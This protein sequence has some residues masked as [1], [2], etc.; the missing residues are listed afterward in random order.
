MAIFTNNVLGLMVLTLAC[1]LKLSTTL[2]VPE[3]GNYGIEPF[4]LVKFSVL[5]DIVLTFYHI[6]P[7]PRKIIQIFHEFCV[8]YC[9]LGGFFSM[10]ADA[11]IINLT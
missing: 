11:K 3:P 2:S 10:I 9:V 8:Q 5:L 1:L 6:V 4:Q 7:S